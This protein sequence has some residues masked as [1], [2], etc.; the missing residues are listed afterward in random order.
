MPSKLVSRKGDGS[1]MELSSYPTYFHMY[2]DLHIAAVEPYSQNYLSANTAKPEMQ[3]RTSIA[4]SLD[5][6]I[7]AHNKLRHSQ[8]PSKLS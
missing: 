3:S 2:R 8:H 4:R 6:A 7:E 5:M 1:A